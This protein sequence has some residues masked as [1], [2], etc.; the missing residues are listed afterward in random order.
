MMEAAE[1]FHGE[2]EYLKKVFSGSTFAEVRDHL[3]RYL[4]MLSG[5]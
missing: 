2:Q 1:E 4:T 3:Q 5:T